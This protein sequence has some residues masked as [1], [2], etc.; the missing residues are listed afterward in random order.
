[1]RR[2]CVVALQIAGVL[3]D[4]DRLKKVNDVHGHAASDH[5]LSSIADRIS[6]G[7]IDGEFVRGFGGDEFV[8]IKVPVSG[9]EEAAR[10]AEQIRRLVAEPVQ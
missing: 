1:M 8:A 9:N 6:S 3:F 10:F 7:M 2:G 5:V 4:F